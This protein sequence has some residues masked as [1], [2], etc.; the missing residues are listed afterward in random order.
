MIPFKSDAEKIGYT[1]SQLEW[2]EINEN[3]IWTYFVEKELIF[4]TDSRLVNRFI[5]PAPYS[6]FY[7]QL[8]NESPARLGQYM[9][10]Q[11]VRAYANRTGEDFKT[12]LKTDAETIFNKSKYKPKK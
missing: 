11:I 6:K 4:K 2:A 7:L 10:W 9:G 12:I 5:A 3:M 1:K 8:D